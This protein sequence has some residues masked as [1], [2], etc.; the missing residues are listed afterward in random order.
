MSAKL[1]PEVLINK[2]TLMAYQLNP[3]PIAKIFIE[4]KNNFDKNLDVFKDNY[5]FYRSVYRHYPD[6]EYFI[7]KQMNKWGIRWQECVCFVNREVYIEDWENELEFKTRNDVVEVFLEN[8]M[9]E[10]DE[11][12]E[13]DWF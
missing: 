9:N 10:Y 1:I 12:I 3:H 11:T 13:G 2:I 7:N 6:Y 8:Y 4:F 5:K